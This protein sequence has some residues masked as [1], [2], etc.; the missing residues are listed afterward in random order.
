MRLTYMRLAILMALLGASPAD[1]GGTRPQE[2]R[3]VLAAWADGKW[4]AAELDPVGGSW[5]V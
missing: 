4:R 1:T 5:K 2:L 3:P